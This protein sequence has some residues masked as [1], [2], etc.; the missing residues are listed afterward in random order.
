[1]PGNPAR[2]ARGSEDA[3]VAISDATRDR[4]SWFN[5]DGLRPHER[6]ERQR[7]AER[8]ATL[9]GDDTRAQAAR[10]R[11][12]ASDEQMRRLTLTSAMQSRRRIAAALSIP[13]PVC[14]A[15]RDEYCRPL[16]H[17]FCSARWEKGAMLAVPAPVHLGP[18]TGELSAR[19]AEQRALNDRIAA[20]RL[21]GGSR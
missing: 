21:R 1:M 11:E 17:G 2:A 12:Q 7:R 8:E 20:S 15:P 5:A 10:S 9:A 18:A 4:L 13:C 16:C 19:A 6:R 3:L 14:A